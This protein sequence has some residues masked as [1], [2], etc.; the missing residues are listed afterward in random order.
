MR[1]RLL[2]AQEGSSPAHTSVGA[3]PATGTT[4]MLKNL[5]VCEVKAMSFPSGLHE[6]SEGLIAPVVEMRWGGPP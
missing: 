4:Q 2:L 1:L 5:P 3:P 6:G